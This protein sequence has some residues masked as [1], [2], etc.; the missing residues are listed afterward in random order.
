MGL[1][2]KNQYFTKQIKISLPTPELFMID[3]AILS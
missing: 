3:N 2:L 1:I